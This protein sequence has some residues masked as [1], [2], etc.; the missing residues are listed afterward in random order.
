MVQDTRPRD[1]FVK[2]KIDL[3]SFQLEVSSADPKTTLPELRRILEVMHMDEDV[4]YEQAVQQDVR[5][6]C[7]AAFVA[8]TDAMAAVKQLV[9]ET[10]S[11]RIATASIPSTTALDLD[12]HTRTGRIANTDVR[13]AISRLADNVELKAIR[14]GIIHVVG[15]LDRDGKV[16]IADHIHKLMP[17][18]QLR[19]FHTRTSESDVLVECVFFGDFHEDED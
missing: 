17:T 2:V 14:H 19:A 12:A 13:K 11:Y 18:A 6:S 15:D 8:N 5:S 10:D 9:R 7:S 4:A 16:L 1:E 3:P